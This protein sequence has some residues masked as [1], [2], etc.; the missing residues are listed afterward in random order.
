MESERLQQAQ[1]LFLSALERAESEQHLFLEKACGKDSELRREVESLL[2]YQKD[3][4]DFIELPA[5]GLLAK[6]IAQ[7]KIRPDEADAPDIDLIGETVSHYRILE[8]VGK[9]GMGVVYKAEDIKLRRFVALKFLRRVGAAP[10]RQGSFNLAVACATPKAFAA[11]SVKRALLP[12]S[13]IRISAPCSRWTS[14]RD[15]R[16][17]P[18]SSSP[19]GP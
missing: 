2:V 18:C 10:T 14:T 11:W 15:R 4:E 3:A 1:K 17:S 12:R 9:G 7:S 13:I 16:S 5:L 19:G 8:R 6:Q